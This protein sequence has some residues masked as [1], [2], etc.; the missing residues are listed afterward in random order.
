M[1]LHAF[2]STVKV[3]KLSYTT[4]PNTIPAIQQVGGVRTGGSSS[5]GAAALSN[6]VEELKR[7][8]ASQESRRSQVR[9]VS[10]ELRTAHQRLKQLNATIRMK[11]G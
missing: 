7:L 3:P 2:M 8:T 5:S 10:L 6:L 11:V 4:C 9:R 1:A